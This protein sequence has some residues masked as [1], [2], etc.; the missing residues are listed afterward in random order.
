MRNIR[1]WLLFIM[2]PLVVLFSWWAFPVRT[3]APS[4]PYDEPP[5]SSVAAVRLDEE[6]FSLC[7]YYNFAINKQRAKIGAC[8]SVSLRGGETRTVCIEGNS[9]PHVTRIEKHRSSVWAT[10][11]VDDDVIVNN[12]WKSL[13]DWRM[14][15]SG[16]VTLSSYM[17]VV[18]FG[19][20]FD[21]GEDTWQ[22]Y[23]ETRGGIPH[24]N[25]HNEKSE[26]KARNKERV[27]K[28]R[29]V[30]NLEL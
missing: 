4:I 18:K 24:S 5:I 22:R 2:C 6:I 20:M 12:S 21:F 9:D 27:K 10:I 15:T 1:N 3:V 19:A 7:D 11:V 17:N 8:I 13:T 14:V 16:R 30:N 26:K 23:V 25:S 28:Q 29:V